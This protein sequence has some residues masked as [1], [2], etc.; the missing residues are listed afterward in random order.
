[1]AYDNGATY[2]GD[3]L[4]HTVNL[5]QDEQDSFNIVVVLTDGRALDA[6]CPMGDTCDAETQQCSQI[7]TSCKLVTQAPRLKALP[8][9]NA[10]VTVVSVGFGQVDADQLRFMAS[11]DGDENTIIAQGE[12][13]SAG[14]AALRELLGNLVEKVCLNLPVDCVF[15][16]TEWSEC[17]DCGEGY[18]YRRID[19]IVVE[20]QNGGQA[21]PTGKQMQQTYRQE[22]PFVRECTTTT[23]STSTSTSTS[24]STIPPTTTTT[25]ATTTST[26]ATTTTVTSEGSTDA[27]TATTSVTT[28]AG[29]DSVRSVV[30]TG[31]SNTYAWSMVIMCSFIMLFV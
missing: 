3:A 24:P 19:E 12:D 1:M 28:I 4:E 15:T 2:T 22:C 21:C 30:N 11:G 17:P 5:L 9:R 29:A 13:A 27:D 20:P 26:I 7:G 23:T 25:A 18:Q 14:L 6:F 10:T 8:D 31:I 16:Y